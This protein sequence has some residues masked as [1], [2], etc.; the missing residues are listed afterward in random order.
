MIKSINSLEQNLEKL[1]DE[2]LKNKSFDLRKAILERKSL[3]DALIEAFALIREAARRTLNQ[4]PFD[5]QLIGG[6]V[7]HQGKIAEM[8]TGEGKTLAAVAPAYF[9]AL[10]GKGVHIITV[11]DYLASRDAVWM[12][13]IYSALGLSV[14]CLTHESA[15]IYDPTYGNEKDKERDISGGFK[16]VHEFLRPVSRK[17][18]Y[19]A[20]VTYGTNHEFG[21]DYLRDNLVYDFNHQ[22]QRGHYYTVIDEIDSILIDEARTPLIIAAPDAESSEYYKVFANIVSRLEK[23][24]DYLVDEKAKSVTIT[25]EGIDKIEKLLNIKN[26]YGSENFRL[27]HYLEESLKA[28]ELFKVDK[29]YVVKDGEIIIVDEFTGRLMHGR[30]Y[31][32]G[33]HQAIEAKEG[34]A[35]KQES[36]TFAQ[37]TIQN[38][39]RL[40]EKISGM[41][42]TAQTSAEEFHKV[43]N[44]EVVSVPTNRLMIRE[45]YS[46]LIYKNR[47]AKYNAVVKNIKKGM[48]WVS[49]F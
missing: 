35:V 10:S 17:D 44:L 38:Y 2:E 42:G 47:E 27:V 21:F 1:T 46:D 4:R 41:T 3:D 33:L 20:D 14:G 13:Q 22:V 30:R 18:A 24:K 40:Y 45:D 34:V 43:Y 26:L 29:Q 9:N 15:Y 11:N 49:Q 39:F 8:R 6:I 23:E 37:I 36:R 5:V 16:V 19:L 7:L 32:A 25:D 12:G 31:S 48:N 28:K